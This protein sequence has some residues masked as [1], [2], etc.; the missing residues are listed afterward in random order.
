MTGQLDLDAC[1]AH[2]AR[3]AEAGVA[4]LIPN[5]S[6]GEYEALTEDER[7]AEWSSRPWTVPGSWS[8][9]SPVSRANRRPRP[10]VGRARGQFRV[11]GR[12]V[13][14][15]DVSCPDAR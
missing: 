2:F 4:G 3:L 11:P 7:S 5:G 10:E 12:H 14:P 13:P 1:Q 15:S 9:W 6:L 8:R